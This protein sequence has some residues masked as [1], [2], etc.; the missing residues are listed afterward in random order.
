[1]IIYAP[2]PLE[3][4]TMMDGGVIFI[5]FF[6]VREPGGQVGS[7]EAYLCIGILHPD[8]YRAFVSGNARQA[9]LLDAPFHVLNLGK[10]RCLDINAQGRADQLAAA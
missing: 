5:P 1:M 8:S 6:I 3:A 2:V 10:H 9:G 7:Y 4:Q